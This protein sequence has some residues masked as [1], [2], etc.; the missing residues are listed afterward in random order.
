MGL[1]VGTVKWTGGAMADIWRKVSRLGGDLGQGQTTKS[2]Y[3]LTAGQVK[4]NALAETIELEAQ[5]NPLLADI[6][7]ELGKQNRSLFD[8][9]MTG[10]VEKIPMSLGQG[11]DPAMVGKN[12]EDAVRFSKDQIG[13]SYKI[14]SDF[15]L[16]P[17][18]G[19]TIPLVAQK[20]IKGVVPKVKQEV[21]NI[22]YKYTSGPAGSER[23][24]QN[25]INL[26][27]E[28]SEN[29]TKYK[30]P[31]DLLNLKR[32][33][34]NKIYEGQRGEVPLYPS[35]DNMAFNE[36]YA[37]LSNAIGDTFDKLGENGKPLREVWDATNKR[38]S[39]ARQ[40]ITDISNTLG[41]ESQK[42]KPEDYM[43]R[44]NNIGAE[45]LLELR[46]L[47]KEEPDLKPVFDEIQGAFFDNFLNRTL[48]KTKDDFSFDKLISEWNGINATTKEAMIPKK[49]ID[50]MNEIVGV[51]SKQKSTDM[52]TQNPSGTAIKAN[53]L[54]V[55]KNPKE[56]VLAKLM[57][58]PIKEYYEKGHVDAFKSLYKISKGYD[59]VLEAGNS[60]AEMKLF[61]KLK[62]MNPSINTGTVNLVRQGVRN[63]LAE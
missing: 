12:L 45:K 39:I 22:L 62:E 31:Q 33:L 58:G 42:V 56:W 10:N 34:G 23:I 19:K 14:G 57:R 52:W 9:M 28:T 18:S 44:I 27:A 35:R 17:I 2:G 63:E 11:A 38:Y 24:S 25:A 29:L 36:M 1:G 32:A 3:K 6:P 40:K 30:K 43:K 16:D 59:K 55:L 46:D 21:D 50:N 54:A 51:L 48:N 26:L 41:I 13:E 37:S 20:G 5:S 7:R 8:Q 4:P 60:I 15:A 53:A 47:A 49:V 61:K